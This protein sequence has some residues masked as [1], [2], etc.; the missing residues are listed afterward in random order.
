MTIA[1]PTARKEAGLGEEEKSPLSQMHPSQQP[2][3]GITE[4]AASASL[5]SASRAGGGWEPGSW[6]SPNTLL[7]P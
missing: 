7:W 5:P 1:F 2:W 6:S 4:P 3:S